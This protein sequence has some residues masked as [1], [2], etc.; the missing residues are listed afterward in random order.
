MQISGL[1]DRRRLFGILRFPMTL[2]VKRSLDPQGGKWLLLR[3][4][5][6]EVRNGCGDARMMTS[7]RYS[8]RVALSRHVCL[9]VDNGKGASKTQHEERAF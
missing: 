6:K 3:A 9:V 7:D 8:K 5:F 1:D 4:R 2:G